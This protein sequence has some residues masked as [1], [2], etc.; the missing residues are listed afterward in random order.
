MLSQRQ[1]QQLQG[2]KSSLEPKIVFPAYLRCYSDDDETDDRTYLDHL[3]ELNPRVS[4]EKL[5]EIDAS[6]V[7]MGDMYAEYFEY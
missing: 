5:K 4:I 7:H 3:I 2:I 1:K 6:V